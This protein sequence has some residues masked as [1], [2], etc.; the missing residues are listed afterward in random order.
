MP[1]AIM[2][3]RPEDFVMLGT[4]VKCNKLLKFIAFSVFYFIYGNL[5]PTLAPAAYSHGSL[6]KQ[7]P[8]NCEAQDQNRV[9]VLY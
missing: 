1:W 4:G 8:R 5:P 3:G 7:W 9:D 2:H 6:T